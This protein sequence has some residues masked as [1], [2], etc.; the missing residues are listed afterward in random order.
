MPEE[1]HLPGQAVTLLCVHRDTV[2]YPLAEVEVNRVV[3][4]VVAAVSDTL[5]V[6]ILLGTDVPELGMLLQ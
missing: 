2:L 3:M 5:P 4:Q 6:P 1:Q